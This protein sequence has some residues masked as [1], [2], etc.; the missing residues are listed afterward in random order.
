MACVESMPSPRLDSGETNFGW[1][2]RELR[3]AVIFSVLLWVFTIP[4]IS[5]TKPV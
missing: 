1:Y 2:S 4:E 5:E 3:H